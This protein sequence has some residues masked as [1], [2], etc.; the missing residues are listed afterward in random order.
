MSDEEHIFGKVLLKGTRDA[1]NKAGNISLAP[2]DI[3]EAIHEA[4]SAGKADGVYL[5]DNALDTDAKALIDKSTAQ[6]CIAHM[7]VARSQ[8]CLKDREEILKEITILKAKYL[9]PKK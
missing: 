3:K 7:R 9:K 5:L 1:Y 4:Y 6:D 8:M 2:K